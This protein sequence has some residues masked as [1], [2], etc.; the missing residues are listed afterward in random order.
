MVN[1]RDKLTRHVLG[2]AYIALTKGTPYGQYLILVG[3]TLSI[4]N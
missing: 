4:N 1:E 3:H 2:V